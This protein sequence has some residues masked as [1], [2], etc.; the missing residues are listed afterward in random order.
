MTE[1][2]II[3]SFENSSQE[4]MSTQ[5]DSEFIHVKQ[6]LKS[7]PGGYEVNTDLTR[8]WVT[9]PGGILK[10][11]K[12]EHKPNVSAILPHD[13]CN[14]NDDEK[15]RV[16]SGKTHTNIQEIRTNWKI[17]S[18]STLGLPLMRLP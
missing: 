6:E 7:D 3:L 10:E 16:Q 15:E 13:D 9:C 2:N 4:T 17:S 14:E 18:T 12:A 8:Y 1:K 11:V 5:G